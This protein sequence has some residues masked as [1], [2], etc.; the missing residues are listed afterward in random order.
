M[1]RELR[2]N[3]CGAMRS[4]K[5]LSQKVYDRIREK[6]TSVEFP[7][8]MVLQ[9]AR[10]AAE[11]GVSRTPVRE[12]MNV[13]LQEGWLD[14]EA[15][16]LKVKQFT[17]TDVLQIFEI[18][19]IL[20]NAAMKKVFSKGNPRLLAGYLDDF[21]ARMTQ[22]DDFRKFTSHDIEFHAAIVKQME[23]PRLTQFWYNIYEEIFRGGL[24]SMSYIANRKNTVLDEH[25]TIV[26]SCWEKDLAKTL[27]ALAEH[28]EHSRRAL[29]QG[30]CENGL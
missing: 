4:R 20:E 25:R 2:R 21:V 18:R 16:V 17:D 22:E 8:G 5:T 3:G 10:L 30:L 1:I 19:S 14:R 6:I 24:W 29:V 7:P 23:N 26:E 27:A 15:R 11:F 13:L 28:H 9:E 12:A